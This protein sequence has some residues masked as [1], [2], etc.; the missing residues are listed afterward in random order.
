MECTGKIKSLGIDLLSN[1]YTVELAL[2]ENK[3]DQLQNLKDKDKL[4]F[5]INQ[6]RKK[7]SLDANA[8]FHVL[9]GKIAKILNP[10]ISEQRCKNILIC[11]YGQQLLDNNDSPVYMKVN[12]DAETMLE[13]ETIHC[14]PCGEKTE[15]GITTNFYRVYRGSH[16]YDTKEMSVLIDG[17]VQ[18][19]KELGID[20]YTP[21][22][23]KEMEERW[24]LNGNGA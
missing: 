23:I 16:T 15:N 18:E 4:S 11:R 17:T 2:N 5:K 21:A 6:Y 12:I 1:K 9:V 19:A 24:H 22:Q 20:T 7:R 14:L 3:L 13:Q 10:P 8:Y